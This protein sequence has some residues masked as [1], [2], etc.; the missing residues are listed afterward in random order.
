MKSVFAQAD[1]YHSF[2]YLVILIAAILPNIQGLI[3]FKLEM[4]PGSD[5][6]SR[7]RTPA[8]RTPSRTVTRAAPA[9]AASHGDR[10]S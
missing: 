7:G 3:Y 5:S 9:A 10:D 4:G 2:A 1:D 6:E 8:A